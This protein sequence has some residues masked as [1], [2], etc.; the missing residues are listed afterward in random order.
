MENHFLQNGEG[1]AGYF[2]KIQRISDGSKNGP[3][4]HL[5]TDVFYESDP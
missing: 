2:L 3:V 4:V 5:F 1:E